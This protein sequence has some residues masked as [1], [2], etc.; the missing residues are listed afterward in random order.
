MRRPRFGSVLAAVAIATAGVI[1]IFVSPAGAT[2]NCGPG[3]GSAGAVNASAGSQ[4]PV[5]PGALAEL[6]VD[7]HSDAGVS[8]DNII[9]HDAPNGIWHHGAGRH[10]AITPVSSSTTINFA[11]GAIT[12][13]DVSR[14]IAFTCQT[15]GSFIVSVAATSAVLSK[16]NKTGCA[17]TTAIIDYTTNR[18]LQDVTCASGGTTLTGTAADK[19]AA[20]DIGKSVTGGP[21]GGAGGGSGG[22]SA[23]GV[24]RIT[25]VGATT[26]TLNAAAPAACANPDVITLG[27]QTYNTT[28]PFAAVWPN[29]PMT[30]ELSNS[31]TTGSPNGGQG[32]TC[33]SGGNLLAL[34]G[35]A[36]GT[37]PAFSAAWTNLKV[38][39]RG[40][41]TVTTKVTGLSGSSL[42]LGASCPAGVSATTGSATIGETD[43]NAPA[44]NTAMMELNA[45]LNLNPAL[46]KTQDDCTR[47]TI[48]GFEVVGSW[49]NPGSYAASVA[50]PVSVG[51]IV[52]PT[53]VVNF[54]GNIVPK[55]GGD[56]QEVGVSHFD[57]VFPSLPTSSAVCLTPPVTGTPSNPTQLALAFASTSLSGDI[58]GNGPYLQTGSGNPQD[59][60]IRA[61]DQR[62]G[63]TFNGR[64]QLRAGATDVTGS[65]GATF[66][67][68][69][70]ASTAA[71]SVACGDG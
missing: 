39:V 1:P 44:N 26:A 68:T 33:A 57:F 8:P 13:L 15:G 37:I 67:C 71:P 23:T 3:A 42:T 18:V 2:N 65:P 14:P 61:L 6:K 27:G 28:T 22:G 30:V 40:T 48:E 24:W 17:A 34:A 58:N 25:A 36:V 19:F 5:G 41:T 29:N 12:S 4:F 59:P 38:V 9:I 21:F 51:Q 62:F 66:S 20:S 64:Y 49:H 46:V 16:A 32:F 45:E 11:S 69:I 60:T 63:Q 52:F 35:S 53:A 43:A 50:V 54:A 10:V 47:N 7:C 56:S 55:K 70:P 31:S